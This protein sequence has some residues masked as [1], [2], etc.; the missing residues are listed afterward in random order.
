M[1]RNTALAGLALLLLLPSL[2]AAHGWMPP[3]VSEAGRRIDALYMHVL[4]IVIVIFVITEGLLLYSVIAFRAKP[5]RRAQFFHGSAGV[6][7]ILA[8]IPALILLYITVVS[9]QLWDRVRMAEPKG[10]AVVQVQVM[11]EQ[12]SWNFRYPGP[13]GAFGTKDD[14]ITNVDAAVPVDTDVVFHISS[15]DVIHSF[16]LPE[17]RLKQDLVPGLLGKVWTRWDLI[18]VWDLAKQERVLLT[19]DQYRAVPV[20]TAGFD[21]NSEANPVKEGWYQ[22]SASDKIN[23]LRYHYD[24]NSDKLVVEKGGKPSTEAPQYMLHYY[25]VACAQLCGNLHFAMR[26]TMHVM[27]PEDYERWLKAQQPDSS[28]SDK[29]ATTW[30]QYHPEYNKVF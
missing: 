21:F 14:V 11:A 6:E 5:G 8:T 9:S 23:Y 4:Y 1:K 10:A 3:A 30:D 7:L 26:G 2:A 18:P 24:R 22:A 16:F 17:S 13:D 29:W 25:E 20:A 15:K 12:F 28:L 27:P 19:L